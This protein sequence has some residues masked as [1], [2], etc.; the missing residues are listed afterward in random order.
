[1][2]SWSKCRPLKSSPTDPHGLIPVHYLRPPRRIP[3]APEPL[4]MTFTP[5]NGVTPIIREFM[6]KAYRA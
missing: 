5:I 3:F 1:M 4:L 6:D 2:T